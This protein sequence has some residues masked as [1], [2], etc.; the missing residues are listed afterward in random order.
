MEPLVAVRKQEFKAAKV[1]VLQIRDSRFG[2]RKLFLTDKEK[3]SIG[4]W[5]RPGR[6]PN[7]ESQN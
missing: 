7:G 1:K 6:G 5:N 2:L 4:A 3:P